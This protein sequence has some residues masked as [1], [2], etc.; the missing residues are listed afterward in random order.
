MQARTSFPFSKNWWPAPVTLI[1]CGVNAPDPRADHRGANIWAVG[2]LGGPCD[3]PPVLTISPRIGM[4]SYKLLVDIGQFV[5][6]FPTPQMVREMEYCGTHT[7]LE[8]DKWKA[9][10]F[11]PIKGKVVD[12]PLIAECPVNFEC[13]IEKQ[14]RLTRD[15]GSDG[16]HEIMIGR[17]VQTH[18]HEDCVVNGELHW[19][20]VDTIYRSRPKTWRTMGP[21][22]GFDARKGPIPR[23]QE[24]M[25]LIEKRAATFEGLADIIRQ[26]P[27]PTQLKK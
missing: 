10:G 1:S 3:D 17:I 15:D 25:E 14:I 13:V 11:T 6:N 12:V 20:L 18:A 7:G 4:Y 5:V 8:V 16:E 2:V 19:D 24:A 9:C 22:L 27:Y 26:T 21:A 23:P